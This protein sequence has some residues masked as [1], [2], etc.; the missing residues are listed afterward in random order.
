MSP[1]GNGGSVV[2]TNLRGWRP[3]LW[4]IVGREGKG[5]GVGPLTVEM[6]GGAGRALA[7][8]GFQEEA[9]MHLLLEAPK[10]RWRIAETSPEG[11]TSLLSGAPS[12]VE[13]VV[14]DPMGEIRDPEANRPLS[15]SR[16]S[17]LGGFL[18]HLL[19]LGPEAFEV[20]STR[21]G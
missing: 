15:M 13:R 6:P 4:V 20:G 10:G 18:G 2:E 1:Y 17:F 3:R 16:E 11:L 5:S 8:F 7:V 21:N 19:A 12:G 14:L 9:R